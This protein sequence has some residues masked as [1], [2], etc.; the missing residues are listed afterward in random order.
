MPYDPRRARFS[1]PIPTRVR[2]DV[3]AQ[4]VEREPSTFDRLTD[5]EK[6]KLDAGW[7]PTYAQLRQQAVREALVRGTPALAENSE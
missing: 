4:P 2:E 7:R 6:K 5:A 3:A 1:Q